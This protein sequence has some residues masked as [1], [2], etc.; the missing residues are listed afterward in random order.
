MK[1]YYKNQAIKNLA[2]LN[3]K[4]QKKILKKILLLKEYPTS[5]KKLK[6]TL[7]GLYSFR[8]W[9]YRIIY[10]LNVNKREILILVV[11]HRQSAY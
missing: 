1:I 7:A 3:Y 4:D 6:G 10:Q 2:K 8:V 11:A 5:G 9:P